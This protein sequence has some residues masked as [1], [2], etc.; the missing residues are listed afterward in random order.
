MGKLKFR[1][2][3]FII[4]LLILI[5][6]SF[7]II[8][9]RLIINEIHST[10]TNTI[11]NNFSETTTDTSTTTDTTTDTTDS[12]TTETT[13]D[14]SVAPTGE[15]P[16]DVNSVNSEI[17]TLLNKE[18]ILSTILIGIMMAIVTIFVFLVTRDMTKTLNKACSY[19]D[20]IS[21]GDLTFE[22]EE[23]YLKRKDTAGE[24]TA[25][26]A[27]IQDNTKHLL[28]TIQ[29]EAQVLSRVVNDAD[30][31]M[32][33]VNKEIDLIT[34]NTQEMSAGM[35]ETAAASQQMSSTSQEIETVARTIAIHA[36][37]GAQRAGDIHSR[38]TVAKQSSTESR[39]EI[40]TVHHEIDQ[41]L[42]QALQDA[43]I[44]SE[45]HILAKSIMDITSQTNLLSLNA[46]IEAARA[47]DA[48]KGFAVVAD[49]IRKLA[50]ES[51]KAVV[52]IQQVTEQVTAAVG[53]LS[54][55][56][57][58]LLDFVSKDVVKNFNDFEGL[59]N[60]YG[61]DA[62]FVDE[63]ATDFSSTSEELLASIEN[64]IEAIEQVNQAANEGAAE[65]S[66]VA[67]SVQI[68][69]EK[70]VHLAATIQ[71]AEISAQKL[72]EDVKAFKLN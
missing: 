21:K 68:I 63:L 36:G 61:E 47:G 32:L 44:V 56:A 38:A 50:E 8:S 6:G 34:A 51:E 3:M 14:T 55:D 52:H 33:E 24:L 26:F 15:F 7:S 27:K 37:D 41:T 42:S 71:A 20:Y 29:N 70:C 17:E 5:M 72:S 64:V 39:N 1:T 53:T 4:I 13:V 12:S 49:E 2:K 11:Q 67:D 31:L 66:N 60:H 48:G 19:A 69:N 28:Q 65:T 43:E 54:K 30:Q 62:E 59:V 45:I 10:V 58:R 35:Q 9:T 23:K 57:T 40:R 16:G 46:S 18:S 22:I 25:S